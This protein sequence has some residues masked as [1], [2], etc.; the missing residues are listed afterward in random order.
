[1]YTA[2]AKGFLGAYKI[3]ERKFK[4]SRDEC[5]EKLSDMLELEELDLSEESPL[6]PLTP[7]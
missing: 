1:L 6:T 4:F 3:K 5:T 2:K 7:D